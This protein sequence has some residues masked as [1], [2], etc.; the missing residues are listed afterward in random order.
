MQDNVDQIL[1]ER[2]KK[3]GPFED[4]ASYTQR[5]KKVIHEGL[6]SNDEFGELEPQAQMVIREGLDMI[7][8]KIGRIVNGDPMY[9]D[10]WDDIAGYAKLVS[11]YTDEYIPF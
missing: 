2:G 7:A 5:L 10:S 1:E 6:D 9:D 4:H 3:Y 8:H 11:K